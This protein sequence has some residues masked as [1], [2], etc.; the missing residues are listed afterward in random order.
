MQ[1]HNNYV[2]FVKLLCYNLT[3]TELINHSVC[4]HLRLRHNLR[5]GTNDFYHF[6]K[7][8]VKFILSDLQKFLFYAL[9]NN[10]LRLGNKLSPITSYLI[11]TT[12]WSN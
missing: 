1:H 4:G 8:S 5:R 2:N 10:K 12:E 7:K 3:S 9:S 11:N 6:D